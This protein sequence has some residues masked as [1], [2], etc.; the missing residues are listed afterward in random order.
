MKI[1]LAGSVRK[2]TSFP[3]LAAQLEALGHAITTKWWELDVD[4]SRPPRW[5]GRM[6]YIAAMAH[7]DLDV[8]VG[9]ADAVIAL[10]DHEDEQYPHKGTLSEVAFALGRRVPVFAVA[11]ALVQL[12]AADAPA[13]VS[14]AAVETLRPDVSSFSSASGAIADSAIADSAIVA[15]AATPQ[16][17]RAGSTY[18]GPAYASSFLFGAQ[19]ITICATF[20]DAL[21]KSSAAARSL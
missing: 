21:H 18:A 4:G 20:E 9:T 11:P 8:G 6:A 10:F 14:S 12:I 17:T 13:Y 1:Y 15:R 3:A 19:G 16:Y 7:R 2:A 5:Q